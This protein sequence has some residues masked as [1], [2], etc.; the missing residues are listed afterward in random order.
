MSATY[1]G[2]MS[3]FGG[4]N[5]AGVSPSE[6]LALCEPHEVDMFDGYFLSLQPRGTTG[7][8]R[9]LDPSSY[10]IA[11][12]WDYDVTSRSY[13][14]SIRVDVSANGKRHLARPIDWGPAEDTGRICDLSP[15]LAE[16]LGLDTDD[17][18]TIEVPHARSGVV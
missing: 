18:C 11:M 8:A 16:A 4:P 10:Y 6:G 17:V 9:R 2:K 5:D 7:L 12:R 15:G 3:T 13:L 1:T 14:Q